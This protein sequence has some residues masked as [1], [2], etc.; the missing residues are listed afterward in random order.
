MAS[1]DAEAAPIRRRVVLAKAGFAVGAAVV[2]GT[3]LALARAHNP[4]HSKQRLRPLS[5]S[6][7]YLAAVRKNI[8]D[9]GIIQPALSSP[10]AATN[11]S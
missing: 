5:A 1:L 7:S 8:G 9:A 6:R 11:L 3:A 10:T 4:G 2:F